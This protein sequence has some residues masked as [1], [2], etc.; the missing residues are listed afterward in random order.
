[1]S[2]LTY[3][4]FETILNRRVNSDGDVNYSLL[5]NVI[6]N[7]E[8]YSGL[9]RLS[10]AKSKLIQNVTQSREIKL[11]DFL[12]ELVTHYFELLGY[13]NLNKNLGYDANGDNLNVDQI[14]KKDGVLYF[15]EQKIRDDHDSTKKRGQFDNF[16]KKINRIK[17]LYADDN[18]I[19]AM[20][21]IDPSLKKNRNYYLGEIQRMESENFN[22]FY[23]SE[24]FEFLNIKHVWD[25]IVD[26]LTVRRENN[27]QEVI[28]IPD[29]DTSEEIFEALTR[30]PNG[31]WNKLNSNTEVYQLLRRELFPSGT[32]IQRAKVA[33]KNK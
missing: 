33:R 18:I 4:D 12:E 15:I 29:F 23:G 25:E 7:P 9:F 20:W 22:L 8:R 14:F 13:E 27:S 5:E 19:G 26:H 1:M 2:L 3:E 24:L 10:N 30:L 21:F 28:N 6:K 32:N 17:T 31:L 11:G 16:T